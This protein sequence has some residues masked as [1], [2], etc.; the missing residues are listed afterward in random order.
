MLLPRRK[1][2][3]LAQLFLFVL[4]ALS[5]TVLLWTLTPKT[6]KE[7]P[8]SF[9]PLA[10]KK[11][12]ASGSKDEQIGMVESSKLLSS[13][14]RAAREKMEEKNAANAFHD[15]QQLPAGRKVIDWVSAQAGK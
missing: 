2:A 11:P 7:D 12:K 4:I 13:G 14:F 3:H 1:L 8:L 9:H 6:F 10:P 15:P 5:I